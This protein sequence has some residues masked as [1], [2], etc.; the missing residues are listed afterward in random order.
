VAAPTLTAAPHRSR[1]HRLGLVLVGLVL[2]VAL[3][4]CAPP[5]RIHTG[6]VPVHLV[7]PE[8]GRDLPVYQ[9]IDTP[10]LNRGGV[11]WDD[12]SS[13][14]TEPGTVVMFA[15]RV[16]HGGPFRTLNYLRPGNLVFIGGSDG[17]TF[18]YRVT[19]VQ[20]T[21]PSWTAILAWRPSNGFGLTLVACDPPG[22]IRYRLVVH[23]EL[24]A[25][26]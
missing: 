1:G 20:I 17:R 11:G 19:L 2:L 25:I 15:H 7:S 23:A 24:M 10:T 26:S 3:G 12:A 22:S 16:S 4:A 21:P 14:L 8:M 18:V 5:R 6:P 13:G 9:G